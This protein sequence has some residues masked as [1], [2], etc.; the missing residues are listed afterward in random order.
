MT[1]Q[2]LAL[3]L[4]LVPAVTPVPQTVPPSPST[5]RV[6]GAIPQTGEA[7]IDGIV[8]SLNG[9]EP[10][11]GVTVILSGGPPN[12]EGVAN[13]LTTTTGSDGRFVFGHLPAGRYSLGARK[14]GYFLRQP[15][16]VPDA[17]QIIVRAGRS[18]T[19]ASLT[20]IQGGTISGRI[21]DPMGRPAATATV[22]AVRQVY[23]D[24][25]PMLGSVKTSTANDR[26][27]YRLF[28][29]EPGEYLVMAEKTLPTGPS[30]GYFPGS[31]DG[32]LAVAVP[33]SEGVEAAR[34]DFALGA[35]ASTVRVSGVVNFEESSTQPGGAA[36]RDS[37]P[38]FFLAPLDPG[39][40]YE[41]IN[42]ISNSAVN[43]QDR[44][45]GKFELRNVRSGPYELFAVVQDRASK[46]Y[47]AHQMIDVGN[48]DVSDI[49]LTL[50]SGTDLSGRVTA[51]LGKPAPPVRIH[52][53]PT[54]PLP[55][56]PGI[57]VVST[58]GA[59]A[60]PDVPESYYII[61]I[62]PMEQNS[63]VA[64]L[65]Q[66]RDSILDRGIV[67]VAPGQANT[68][69]ALIQPSTSRIRGTVLASP[70]QLA[71]GVIITL[72]P[73]ES[74]RE[75]LGLYRRTMA[76]DGSFSIEGVA[77]GPYRLLAWETIPD[78]AEL[79]AEFM[80]AYR[81]NGTDL[82]VA[83]GTTSSVQVRLISK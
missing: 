34:T 63:Y 33:V 39:R 36:A 82:V 78:G 71:G 67:T 41:G 59:F 80:E 1:R 49:L 70:A 29:L 10:I 18:T 64:E 5:V 37:T 2:F 7:G 25:R 8:R 75:N 43:I 32:R 13:Q 30:R 44:A 62:E 21:L 50:K 19:S 69:E 76:I 31:D 79:N 24:G 77:P 28:W 45:A 15:L 14:D 42:P 40:L 65:I 48:Q 20:M 26:G 60:I 11:A 4:L 57:T 55:N 81:D 16:G 73:D 56:W 38:Q 61:V 51:G 12:P 6:S 53:R 66:G 68:L 3:F 74:R 54:A 58:D 35:M 23:Q 52:L 9:E 47:L 22:S 72:I 27:E 46:Y 83:L 17:G